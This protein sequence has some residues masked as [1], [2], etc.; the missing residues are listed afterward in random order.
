MNKNRIMVR[1]NDFEVKILN[2]NTINCGK[3]I[4]E[5]LKKDFNIE[6]TN[7]K[8]NTSRDIIRSFKL[9]DDQLNKLIE[10]STFNN[11]KTSSMLRNMMIYHSL[12]GSFKWL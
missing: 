7:Y 12:I 5:I 8:S 11:K 3:M 1:L 9:S 2:K 10:I 4:K 6:Y